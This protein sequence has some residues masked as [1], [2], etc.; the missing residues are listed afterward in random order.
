MIPINAHRQYWIM[1]QFHRGVSLQKQ[2]TY[3]IFK[4][5]ET[6]RPAQPSG[7]VETIDALTKA[8]KFCYM[9]FTNHQSPRKRMSLY[10]L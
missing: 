7:T 9:D 4:K 5:F 1:F 6:E 3:I 10:L 2:V 8:L